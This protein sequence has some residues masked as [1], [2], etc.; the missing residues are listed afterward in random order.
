VSF[1]V[2]VAQFEAPVSVPVGE[3]ILEAALAQDLAYPHGCRSGNC[4]ACKS[5]LLA[6]E[7]DLLPY[8]EF[9]L[10]G[11]ERDAGKILACRAV[12]WS[13]CAVRY[14]EEEDVVVHAQRHLTTRIVALERVAHDVVILRLE[15]VAGGPFDFTP[16]QYAALR[17]GGLPERDFSMASLPGDPYLEFHVRCLPG[18]V[19]SAYVASEARID[20]FVFVTG[21]FGNAYLREAHAGPIL[22]AGGGTGLAPV[23]SIAR[24]AIA[25]S[26]ARPIRLF[27]GA[28]DERDVY[29]NGALSALHDAGRDVRLE[30]V[31]SDPSGPT[32]RRTGFLADALAADRADLDGY[33]AYLAG[34]PVMV[35]TC[36]AAL[37]ARGLAKRDIHADAFFPAAAVPARP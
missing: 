35:D 27:F 16:G 6:G 36:T 37:V 31:L 23:L 25:A 5:E 18:G 3:T 29:A 26:P 7:V 8:S 21:P 10:T 12:P 14:L 15:I 20:E 33:H 34:P 32:A 30:V 1:T 4:G 22:L 2:R 19:A 11:A 28:R 17:F 13:D 24:A 9:A